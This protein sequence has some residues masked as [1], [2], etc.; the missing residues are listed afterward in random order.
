MVIN[1]ENLSEYKQFKPFI[2]EMIANGHFSI[3]HIKALVLK[4]YGGFYLDGDMHMH[5]SPVQLH[6]HAQ[7][8]VGMQSNLGIGIG[9]ALI[10]AKPE[11]P[12][13]ATW[14]GLLQEYH[15]LTGD[16]YGVRKL[17]PN[18]IECEDFMLT[19]GPRML[20]FAYH[21]SNNK[22]ENCDIVL[23]EHLVHEYVPSWQL[24]TIIHKKWPFSVLGEC[25]YDYPRAGDSYPCN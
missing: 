7:M 6:H 20:S 14:F 19:T 3:E 5:N 23:H 12:V 1:E 11:H 22:N 24:L 18:P 25:I 2:E 21:V 8:Y 9:S 15:G 4:Q 10:G 17:F 13:I 16:K